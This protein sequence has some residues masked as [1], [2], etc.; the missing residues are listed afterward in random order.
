MNDILIVDAHTHLWE[1]QDGVVDGRRSF[2]LVAG[3]V[4]LAGKFAR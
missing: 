4:I 3:R 1:K 2:P